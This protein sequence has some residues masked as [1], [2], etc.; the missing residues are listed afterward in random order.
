[1][2][3]IVI[4]TINVGRALVFSESAAWE[5]FWSIC[6][7]ISEFLYDPVDSLSDSKAEWIGSQEYGG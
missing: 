6:S 7:V 2:M 5:M 4:E 3:R 1:M